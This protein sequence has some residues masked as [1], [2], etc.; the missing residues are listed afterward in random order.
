MEIH[1]EIAI[2]NYYYELFVGHE[3][4]RRYCSSTS[5]RSNYIDC[6]STSTSCQVR[7]AGRCCAHCADRS[8]SHVDALDGAPSIGGVWG[9]T[10]G[11]PRAR[12]P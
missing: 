12:S 6:S 10:R 2:M 11:N 5:S 1:V 4:M 8:A 9:Q 3:K 7:C